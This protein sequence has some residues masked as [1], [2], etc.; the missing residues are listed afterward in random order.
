[1]ET[2]VPTHARAHSLVP[3]PSL[4]SLVTFQI[5]SLPLSLDFGLCFPN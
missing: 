5:K 3:K 4:P 1:M 2:R